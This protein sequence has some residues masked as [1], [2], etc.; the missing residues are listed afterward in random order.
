MTFGHGF[1]GGHAVISQKRR[2]SGTGVVGRSGPVHR[3]A[4]AIDRGLSGP[5][6]PTF[7]EKI[8][9]PCP[10]T[11]KAEFCHILWRATK[12]DGRVGKGQGMACNVEQAS[13]RGVIFHASRGQA[14]REDRP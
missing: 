5:W 4:A 1:P 10:V 9:G 3:L 13:G 8:A 2:G 11:K 14:R 7:R 6:S 12:A